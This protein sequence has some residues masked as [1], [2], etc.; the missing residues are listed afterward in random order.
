MRNEID[1]QQRQD[2]AELDQDREGLAELL[3]GETEKVL[4]QQQIP[5]DDTG[6]NSV[7][8]STMPRTMDLTTSAIMRSAAMVRSATKTGGTGRPRRT[9]INAACACG[10]TSVAE[11]CQSER[12]STVLMA[13]RHCAEICIRWSCL[14]PALSVVYPLESMLTLLHHP[15][16]PA[17]DFIRLVLG[18]YGLDAGLVD[19]RVWEPPRGL[20]GAQ[21]GRHDA[22]A[23]RRKAIRRCRASP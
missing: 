17:P 16:C 1:R 15:F 19:E 9:G 10:A 23:D 7:N 6:T 12:R 21:P 20:P 3:V 22:G 8:P 14:I 4:D 5:V 13:V 11:Q 2:R 18:E